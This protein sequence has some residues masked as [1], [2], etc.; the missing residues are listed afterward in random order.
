[1]CQ[2]LRWNH[3][4]SQGNR[5]LDAGLTAG[6]LLRGIL[7]EALVAIESDQV[8]PVPVNPDVRSANGVT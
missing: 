5:E 2:G 3:D 1:V 7:D 4:R 6:G 8:R